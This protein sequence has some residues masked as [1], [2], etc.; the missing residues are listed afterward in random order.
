MSVRP[1]FRVCKGCNQPHTRPM[2]NYCKACAEMRNRKTKQ[3]HVGIR[4]NKDMQDLS[5][6]YEIGVPDLLRAG[7]RALKL[8]ETRLSPVAFNRLLWPEEY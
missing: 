7:V 2:T 4:R 6:R 3:P 5:E 1:H 8:L